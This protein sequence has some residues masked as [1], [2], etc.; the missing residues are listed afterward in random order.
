MTAFIHVKFLS[1]LSPYRVKIL[2]EGLRG[3]SEI[4]SSTFRD[5]RGNR[6][7][8]I[9]ARNNEDGTSF[10]FISGH[11]QTTCSGFAQNHKIIILEKRSGEDERLWH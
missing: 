10:H 9:E 6:R 4:L 1:L 8:G 5:Q 3:C 7:S 11:R 2:N